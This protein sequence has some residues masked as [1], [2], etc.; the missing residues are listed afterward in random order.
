MVND[1]IVSHFH[2][3]S[4]LLIFLTFQHHMLTSF[5][6]SPIFLDTR[7]EPEKMKIVHFTY[8]FS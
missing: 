5:T 8:F 7:P 3:F 4:L 6:F 1:D 2:M